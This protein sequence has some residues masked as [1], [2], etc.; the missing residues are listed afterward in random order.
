MGRQRQMPGSRKA[1][2][3]NKQQ[4][5]QAATEVDLVTAAEDKANGQAEKDR[6]RGGR[7]F[8]AALQPTRC[9]KQAARTVSETGTVK[10]AA[11]RRGEAPFKGSCWQK[12]SKWHQAAVGPPRLGKALATNK[13]KAESLLPV[14]I[15]Q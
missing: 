8:A 13:E 3:G 7:Q 2:P 15:A 14:S 10:Q 1:E 5:G 4:Q 12:V 11:R 9:R 6:Q